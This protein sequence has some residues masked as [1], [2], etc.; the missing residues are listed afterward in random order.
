MAPVDPSLIFGKY[1]LLRR[2]AVGGMGEIFLARQVGVSGFMRPVILK[3][4]LP[5][6]AEHEDSV[7]MFLDEARVAAHLN[8]PNVVSLLE[9][10][11]WQGAFY[12]AMEYIEGENLD[13][14]SRA[15]L[16][17]GAPLS[18]RVCAQ[19]VR[20]AAVGLDH[21]HHATDA[22]GEPLRLV[23]RDISPQNIMVR[24][25]GVTKVVDFGVAKASIRASRTRTGVLKGK[26]RY[27]SP[28]QVRNEPLDGRSD[29]FS[30]G[31][32]LWEL[33]ARRPLID[34]DNPAEALQRISTASVPPPSRFAGDL[35]PALEAIIL[36]MLARPREQRF[37]RCQD[38]ARALQAF[39]D[40]VP[41][42]PGESVS[43]VVTQLV[44]EVVR[45][46]MRDPG[47]G[48]KVGREA[49]NVSCPRCGQTTSA[50]SRF[51]PSCGA[52]LGSPP[53]VPRSDSPAPPGPGGPPVPSEG[54]TTPAL[55]PVAAPSEPPTLLGSHAAT[56]PEA[57]G[58]TGL[59]G[60]TVRM[61]APEGQAVLRRLALLLVQV[62]GADTGAV[63]GLEAALGA[64]AGRHGA[65]VVRCAEDRWCVALGL[66]ASRPDDALRAARC[67]LHL[68]R[69]VEGLGLSPPPVLRLGLEL[70]TAR[71]EGGEEGAGWRVA[72]VAFERAQALAAQAAPG[73][74]A[75][76]E[77]LKA[78]LEGLVRFGPSRGPKGG[79]L[80]SLGEPGGAAHLAPFVGHA[81]ALTVAQAV[82]DS[83]RSLAGGAWLFTGGPGAGKSR[84]LE[85]V[86]GLAAEATPLRMVQ[87]SAG[88]PEATGPL[89]VVR[90]V[91]LALAGQLGPAG[92]GLPL[93]P[94]A[95]LGFAEAELA[96]LWRRLAQ[97]ASAGLLPA[98]DATVARALQRAAHPTG[99]LL[100][101]DDLHQVD[102]P[103]LELLATVVTAPT[104]RVALMGTALP[105]A[106]P[107]ALEPL[108]ASLLEG[109]AWTELR[110]LLAS[111]FGATFPPD[112]ERLLARRARGSPSLALE[113]MRA[114]L[115][116]AVLH[117]SGKTWRT[118]GTLPEAFLP[119][120]TAQGLGARLELL[121]EGARQL[122]TRAAA[123]GSFFSADLVRASLAEERL[124]S[125]ELLEWLVEDGWVVPAR[126]GMFRF[127]P[128]L[129]RQ[130]LLER[131]PLDVLR[132]AHQALAEALGRERFAA[133][134]A[135]E[136]REA[137]HLL[138]AR[139]P[140]AAA[141]CERAADG[142]SARGEWRAA[143]EYY[144]HA[145]G[146]A[147]GATP[148][149]VRRQLE[150]LA[151]AA[152]CLT[153]VEPA[154][155][156]PLVSPW[157]EQLSVTHAPS[158][159][160]EASRRI[161]VAELKLGR[162]ADAEVRLVLAQEPAAEDPE[163][164]AWVL[165]DLARVREARGELAGAVELLAQA[166]Q[167]MGSRAAR[168]PA[169]Y[170]EHYLL[171]GRLQQ[172]LGQPERARVAFLRAHEQARA[173]G[174]AV[175]Q[176]LA[177][178]S[179]A[180]LRVLVGEPA[181][182]TL[183]D[184]ERALVLAERAGDA[185]EVARIHCNA[186]RL[187]VASGRIP[188]GRERLLLAR[189]QARGLR[190]REGEQLAHQA[191]SALERRGPRP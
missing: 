178:S 22:Q 149:A 38:V 123:A 130:V 106:V 143:A 133:E 102:A 128:A 54:V 174:S 150:V 15:A 65:E 14:L 1:A 50:T 74:V 35:P 55:P 45:A 151:R 91:F 24:L 72:G 139:A 153:Q 85:A 32:V 190:W 188:E 81:Q 69:A 146:D 186:G 120:S 18:F 156:A 110:S 19:L 127:A 9:V 175:G 180:S 136:L 113:L 33:C 64:V 73:E 31:V 131:T 43:A 135:R 181:P 80:W 109:M 61:L 53:G 51:C 12:I 47:P 170:W 183:A 155:V 4:L 141:R 158:A 112:L 39:L 62:Q 52:A 78:Q 145:M 163:V 28:E 161:A 84:F 159:W 152:G 25:D 34:T 104:S 125:A 16:R 177:L 60:P 5:D 154:A 13:R 101:V 96:A 27:M 92:E 182:A 115:A 117:R 36:R 26:L 82:V 99:L 75:V 63:P 140:E 144:R 107:A 167:R 89:G 114:L 187:L 88:E 10:G 124:G 165:G 142:L 108:P 37:D 129:G 97:G 57:P 20:D 90:S 56:L 49:S 79:A 100:L 66:R 119:D 58:A 134:P 59:P 184:L 87:V 162:V 166:F 86:A 11:E 30:L 176:A 191:L 171:L 148:E 185:Q 77:G 29:Q 6:V 7:E 48:E 71:V 121:P 169:F 93:R 172:R 138:A 68:V 17:S 164:H 173:V 40:E 41:E 122:L 137:T 116:R 67:A 168:A 118:S 95:Q 70:D 98:G 179:L 2:L 132:R 44:G 105:D 3:S 8:H 76:G 126:Q 21:A 103:S 157:L 160:A 94:L 147:P 42:P 83:A 23:H 189:E 46:R 111:T